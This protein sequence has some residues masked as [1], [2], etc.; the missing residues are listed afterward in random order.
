M[1]QK[2]KA[3][4]VQFDVSLGDVDRNVSVVQRRLRHLT[5]RGVRLVVLPEMWSSGFANDRLAAFARATP[6]VLKVLA[7]ESKK[8]GITIIGSLPEQSDAGIY[9]TAYVVDR[10]AVCADYRKVHLFTPTAEE[11]YFISGDEAVV[12]STSLGM[13]GLM[14]C[15][16]LRFPE[17]CRVLALRGAWMIVVMAQWPAVRVSHWDLLLRA[18]AVE[19]QTF[20]L[21][22]NR[23]GRDDVVYGGHSRIVSPNGEVL[24]RASKRSGTISAVIDPAVLTQARKQIPCLEQIVGSPFLDGKVK[25]SRSR[26]REL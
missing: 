4:I 6:D 15:Y 12:A 8:A 11:R 24:A 9:N 5:D 25:S 3:G 18:R 2:V 13:I 17:L 20:V 1:M 22:A 19:N 7:T 21:G 26:R 10:G 16:D 23:S 14:I